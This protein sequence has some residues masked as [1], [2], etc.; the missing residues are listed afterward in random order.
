MPYQQE[1]TSTIFIVEDDNANGAL[2]TEIILQETTCNALLLINAWQALKAVHY[3]RPQLLVIDYSLPDM[4]GIELYDRL[5]L[6]EGLQGVPTLI[7]GASLEGHAKEIEK[8]GLIALAK[9]FELEDFLAIIEMLL[10]S[11]IRTA[12]QNIPCYQQSQLI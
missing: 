10:R 8:R 5:Q 12:N 3:Q 6:M 11:E 1:G 7:I 9:P 4:T 2:F